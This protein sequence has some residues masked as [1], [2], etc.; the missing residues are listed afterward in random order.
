[1]SPLVILVVGITV[2]VVMILVL[3]MNAF[4][5]LIAAAFVASLLMP[6]DWGEK[7]A[8]VASALGTSAGSI[9]IVIAMAAIIGKCM[10]LS[11]AAERIVVS[12]CRILGEKRF[13]AAL[14]GS[15]FVLGI[16]VF[17]DTVFYLLIPLARS[18]YKKMRKN[19]ILCLMA[20]CAG[21]MITHSMVPPTPGPLIIASNLGIPI[22]SMMLVGLFVGI[23]LFPI[24]IAASYLINW[25]MPNPK[26]NFDTESVAPEEDVVAFSSMETVMNERKLPS[27]GWS[28]L[29]IAMPVILIA[30]GAACGALKESPFFAEATGFNLFLINTVKLLGSKDV[31]MMLSAAMAI[32]VYYRQKIASLNEI[33]NHLESALTDAGLII[34]ITAAGGAFGKMLQEAKIGDVIA[35]TLENGSATAG[36]TILLATFGVSSLLKLSLG[37]ST[38]AMITSSAIFGTMQLNSEILGFHLAYLGLTIS[39]GSLVTSWMND[40][41]FWVTSRMAGISEIDTL[42]SVS[43]L[44]I[45]IGCSGFL[46]I[47]LFTQLF[48]FV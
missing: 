26:T 17:Y 35:S 24:G 29:P 11:G 9:A 6:G 42:K 30:L 31:A 16:P 13:P 45:I 40:S 5:A 33:R 15:G 47:L 4:L 48:P 38:V 39:C 22:G 37:S 34:L 19:Y 32:L 3:R 1:M 46:I 21:A 28:L 23:F 20:I 25:Y 8:R 41:G 14:C 10:M 44:H 7:G 12:L 18:F 2:V 27:L 36:I 43:V